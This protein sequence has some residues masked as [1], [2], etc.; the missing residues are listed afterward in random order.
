[1]RSA[2]A[3]GLGL[4]IRWSSRWRSPAS[5]AVDWSGSRTRRRAQIGSSRCCALLVV[6]AISCGSPHSARAHDA[7]APLEG[8][9]ARCD[10]LVGAG[11]T[12]NFSHWTDGLV[13][14]VTLEV[15]DSRWEIGAFRIARR[16]LLKEYPKFAASTIA[17]MPYWGFTA[18]HRWQVLHRSRVRLYVGFGANYRT[19]TDL[20]TSTKWNFAGMVAVR[21]DLGKHAI[22]E[23]AL[24]HWSNAWIRLPDRG[25]NVVTVTVGF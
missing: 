18:M 23:F 3:G 10:L 25:Q 14:P 1:M 13:L 6:A 15:D 4:G 20:L 19:E 11:D 5:A 21:F 8:F 2:D 7:A 12:T 9:C 17:T 16:Q 24:R 22:L